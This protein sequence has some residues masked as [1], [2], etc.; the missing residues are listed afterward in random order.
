MTRQTNPGLKVFILLSVILLFSLTTISAKQ[1]TYNFNSTYENIS[2][3]AYSNSES[4][5]NP[6]ICFPYS[7]LQTND[8]FCNSTFWSNP[9]P[10]ALEADD[11]FY[12]T[13]GSSVGYNIFQFGAKLINISIDTIYSLNWTYVL[14]GESTASFDTYISNFT[15]DN[16]TYISNSGGLITGQDKLNSTIINSGFSS[17]FNSSSNMTYLVFISNKTQTILRVDYIEL[18]ILYHDLT[19]NMPQSNDQILNTLTTTLNTSQTSFNDTIWYSI[20]SGVT[21]TTL[22]NNSNECQDTITF[23]YQGYFNLS[24]W[25]NNSANTIINKNL[26]NIFVGNLTRINIT[27]DTYIDGESQT[28]VAGN[29]TTL[30]SGST[31]ASPDASDG[32]ILIYANLSALE[33]TNLIIYNASLNIKTGTVYNFFDTS[34]G[35]DKHINFYEILHSWNEGFGTHTSLESSCGSNV[36]S[37]VFNATSWLERWYVD[38]AN[39][40]NTPFV[41][42]DAD[43][44]SSGLGSSLDYNTTSL[45]TISEGSGI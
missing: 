34:F 42:N 5:T 23:P 4:S 40:G 44:Q 45:K 41:D 20:N 2:M 1:I 18:N 26:N 27:K 29:S 43:W 38:N 19:V 39:D 6:P 21:N 14:R 7:Y 3:F 24:V 9:D 10:V 37:A 30:T 35:L 25:A 15:A 12:V 11:I 16:W 31:D 33:N 32:R 13:E 36:N 22:C 8:G 28:C 17:Y